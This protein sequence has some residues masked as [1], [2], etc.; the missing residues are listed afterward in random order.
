[1]TEIWEL[2]CHP[3]KLNKKSD[4]KIT[5][6]VTLGAGYL[7]ICSQRTPRKSLQLETQ[8]AVLI[9]LLY[10]IKCGSSVF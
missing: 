1:M 7:E 3:Q 5:E 4:I 6:F 2:K 10:K 9:L 8:A